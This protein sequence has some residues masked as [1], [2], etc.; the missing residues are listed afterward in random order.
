MDSIALPI[1][2]VT[3]VTFVPFLIIRLTRPDSNESSYKTVVVFKLDHGLGDDGYT[4]IHMVEVL[5]YWNQVPLFGPGQ[6]IQFV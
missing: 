5:T 4:F 6:G 3:I 2:I 1:L